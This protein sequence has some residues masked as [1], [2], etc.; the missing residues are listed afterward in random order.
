M[1]SFVK[2][3]WTEGFPLLSAHAAEGA[4]GEWLGLLA[5]IALCLYVVVYSRQAKG[6]A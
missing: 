2:L 6:E 1:A 4:L 3:K 5:L